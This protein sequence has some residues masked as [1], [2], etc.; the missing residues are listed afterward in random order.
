MKKEFYKLI[1][2]FIMITFSFSLAFFLGRE[3]TLSDKHQP[4]KTKSVPFKKEKSYNQPFPKYSSGKE[5]KQKEKVSEYKKILSE[6]KSEKKENQE[7]R[8]GIKQPEGKQKDKEMSENQ[9]VKK[10]KEKADTQKPE[11]YALLVASYNNKDDAI[12]KSTGL[13]SRF[14]QWKIFFKKS[15]NSYKVYIG[16]FRGKS[17]TEN[18]LKELQK[19]SDFSSVKMEKI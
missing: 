3:V 1:L 19:E 6:K 5:I 17:S 13:K 10:P 4:E 12:R 18:F 11:I 8:K 2:V 14:P 15:G 7:K 9:E 16:P